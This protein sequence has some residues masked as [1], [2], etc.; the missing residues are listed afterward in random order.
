MSCRVFDTK[1][2]II[3]FFKMLLSC[4]EGQLPRTPFE[5]ISQSDD[6]IRCIPSDIKA[7]RLH[8]CPID[9][10][11]EALVENFGELHLLELYNTSFSKC[12]TQIKEAF[13]K[14]L[15]LSIVH[16]PMTIV[17]PNLLRLP[18]T[19]SELQ[20]SHTQITDLTPK[21][22][23]H[24]E[25]K[26]LFL[27]YNQFQYIPKRLETL[28]DVELLSLAGNPFEE[29]DL[30]L[31]PKTVEYLLL[32]SLS[33][34]SIPPVLANPTYRRITH[35]YLNNNSIQSVVWDDML[36]L[37]YEKNIFQLDGCPICNKDKISKEKYDIVCQPTCAI[38]CIDSV[39][40]GNS[41]CNIECNTPAC[42]YDGGDC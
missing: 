18:L 25:L 35:L 37:L 34:D 42:N 39:F 15:A 2:G 17:P 1:N 16:S 21:K 29:I 12:H 22:L 7:L 27:N 3:F 30:R 11:P 32:P 13:P 5:Y 10:L 33:M 19:T 24:L 4:M 9:D 6:Y 41:H 31:L 38:G 28:A 36:T 8:H 26:R 14:M 40:V 23:S 20:I